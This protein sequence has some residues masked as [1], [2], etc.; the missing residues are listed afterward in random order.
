MSNETEAGTQT[1]DSSPDTI[2]LRLR[3]ESQIDPQEMESS[4][5]ETTIRSVEER[6]KQAIDPILRRVEQLCS[7]LAGRTQL[8]SAGN[9]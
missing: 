5:D 1:M 7:L 3:Q 6:I 9:N 2:D 8:V 4:A